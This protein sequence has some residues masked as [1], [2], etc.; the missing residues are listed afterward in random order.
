[1]VAVVAASAGIAISEAVSRLLSPSRPTHLPAV[2]A[3]GLVGV[4][5]NELVARYRSRVGKRIGSA[6]LVADGLH[7]RA[8]GVASLLVVVAALGVACGLR[9]AD[10]VMG[11]LIAFVIMLILVRTARD[12][13]RRLLD[14]V[15]PGVVHAIRGAAESVTGVAGAS[16]VRARWIGHRL[17]AEVRLSV[18]G[19]LT[20][21]QGHAVAEEVLHRLLH[22]VPRL[23]DAIVHVD[24]L[25]DP[26]DLT[27]HHR[28]AT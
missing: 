2:V 17:R 13:G 20:V 26:H 28:Q 22:D 6:A 3:A 18:A 15:D 8:D 10:P 9:W 19:G 27:A 1:V 5:G 16:E 7:A 23:A 12:I 25:A 24:P 14:A 11:I 4:V 21:T